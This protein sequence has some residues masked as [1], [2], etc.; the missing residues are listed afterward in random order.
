MIKSHWIPA[1]DEKTRTVTVGHKMAEVELP[2]TG[3]VDKV[4]G[5]KKHLETRS[6]PVNEIRDIPE[7]ALT[8]RVNIK[9]LDNDI[10][11][12][13]NALCE[14]GCSIISVLPVHSFLH[15]GPT[16]EVRHNPTSFDDDPRT[17]II[18]LPVLRGV[19]VYYDD[20]HSQTSK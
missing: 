1:F 16:A 13:M 20:G 5:R 3:I 8:G 6:V 7:C 4:I 14:E 10:R 12:C 18:P 11:S 9:R 2:A 15:S 19:L 17:D